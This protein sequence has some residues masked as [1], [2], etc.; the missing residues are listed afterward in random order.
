MSLCGKHNPPRKVFSAVLNSSRRGESIA[1][2]IIFFLEFKL[3][4]LVTVLAEKWVGTGPP[5]PSRSFAYGLENRRMEK[6]GGGR[7]RTDEVGGGR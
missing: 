5:G 4:N 1:I 7:R 2:F 6:D 3:K